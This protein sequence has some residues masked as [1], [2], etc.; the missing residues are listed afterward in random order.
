MGVADSPNLANLFGYYFERLHGVLTNPKIPF[1]GRYIDDCLAIVYATSEQ[2]AL[3]I[4]SSITFD[5][6]VIE[7]N[8][9][10]SNQPFLDMCVYKT[11]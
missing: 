5:G 1:Y 2:E 8:V 3:N 10:Y 6:C 4:V 7:W 11:L 9:S